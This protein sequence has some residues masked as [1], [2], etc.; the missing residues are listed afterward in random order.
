MK[1]HITKEQLSDSLREELNGFSS[2][3]EH[4]T[5]NQMVSV[6]EF[7]ADPTYTNDSTESIQKAIDYSNE[8]GCTI[9]F[10]KG[11]YK[12][13]GT[14]YVRDYVSMKGDNNV[15]TGI[16]EF[17]AQA[18]KNTALIVT[19]S[20]IVFQG[21]DKHEDVLKKVKIGISGLSFQHM[22]TYDTCTLFYKLELS[23]SYITDSLF[24]GY[25]TVVLGIISYV[26]T[27]SHNKFFDCRKYFIKSRNIP[28][29]SNS[30]PP[31]ITDSYI[32]NNY[33]NG[34]VYASDMIAFDVHYANYSS[35]EG[36]FIDF[37]KIGFNLT[38][39]QGLH[40]IN[41]DIQYCMRGIY[42]SIANNISITS[43]RFGLMTYEG[44][45]NAWETKGTDISN[46]ETLWSG[47]YIGSGNREITI[48]DNQGMTIDKLIRIKGSGMKDIDIFGNC[49]N[50][51]S[52][53]LLIEEISNDP[54]FT[55]HG[56]RIFIRDTEKLPC[57][58]QPYN[59]GV[60]TFKNHQVRYKGIPL[61]NTGEGR[62]FRT[63]SGEV[64]RYEIELL[65]RMTMSSVPSGWEL[66]G[67]NLK[68]NNTITNWTHAYS[69]VI[70]VEP[71][72][73]YITETMCNI[74]QQWVTEIGV[75]YKDGS[76]STIGT[77]T[78][79]PTNGEGMFVTPKGCKYIE[80]DFTTNLSNTDVVFKKP[81]IKKL[82]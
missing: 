9:Y 40:I 57:I 24:R 42:L 39:G 47:I 20:D 77:K 1:G 36:N 50:D 41:N 54:N 51:I 63:M 38:G 46:W 31:G 61:I 13:E 78:T 48:S 17:G 72:S 5:N 71:E 62:F 29:L 56:E 55:D 25:G 53:L 18:N 73:H 79:I 49:A 12:V 67:D 43:N 7:G 45:K 64:Y 75:I 16:N 32:K 74:T 22:G 60:K 28:G 27:I 81:S 76:K 80:L 68:F 3:L 6:L 59:L 82:K 65:P 69:D 44:H 34:S 10:P 66:E 4:I 14:L 58:E 23:G 52:K 11:K 35:I 70:S 33:I 19:F 8:T 15:I 37:F 21:I 2:Q 30:K 26:T